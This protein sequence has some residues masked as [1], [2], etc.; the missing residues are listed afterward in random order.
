MFLVTK[1]DADTIRAAFEAGGEFAAAVELRRRFRG[2][3]NNKMAR[4]H[5]RAIMGW[6]PLPCDRRPNGAPANR[7][8]P[9]V[10]RSIKGAAMSERKE[11]KT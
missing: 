2:I 1:A 11:D 8:R 7:R 10:F 5:V 3:A 9:N 6:R 4:D